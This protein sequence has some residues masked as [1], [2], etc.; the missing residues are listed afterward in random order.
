M[1]TPSP[2][3]ASSMARLGKKVPPAPEPA[4]TSSLYQVVLGWYGV[5]GTV[6]SY[7]LPFRLPFA[8][9]YAKEYWRHALGSLLLALGL[10]GGLIGLTVYLLDANDFKGQIVDYVKANKQRDLVLEGDLQLDFFPQLGLD[11]GKMSLSQ[12]NSSRTF[13]AVDNARLYIAWWPLLRGRLQVERVVLDGLH[14]D[15]VRHTDGS[16]NFDDLLVSAAKLA[17]VDFAMEKLR[18]QRAHV[19]YRD[20]AAGLNLALQDLEL[21]TGRLADATAGRI[22][23]RFQLVSEQPRIDTRVRLGGHLLYEH[24]GL[25]YQFKDV[26]ARA[27]G[28]VAGWSGL[29]LDLRGSLSAQPVL[30]L[31]TLQQFDA[32]VRGPWAGQSAELRLR[33]DQL[34]LEA[35]Q[36]QGKALKLDGKLQ[37]EGRQLQAALDVP[38]L[39]SREQTLRSEGLQATL[40]LDQGSTRLQ[41]QLA[42]PAVLDYATRQLQLPSLNGLWNASHALLAG[43]LIA[44]RFNGK[45]QADWGRQDARLDFSTEIEDS[46][47][48]GDVQLQDFRAPAWTFNV[49]ATRLDLDR[50]LVGDWP[51]RLQAGTQVQDWRVLQG[52]NLRGRL[53]TEELRAARLQASAVSIG[54]RVAAGTLTL[55]PVQAQLYGGSFQGE[56]SLGAI[57]DVTG[58]A[59]AVHLATRQK[60][61]NV[62]AEDL[63]ALLPGGEGRLS[64]RGQFTLDV[65]AQGADLVA[66]RQSLTG[67]ASV[68]LARGTLAGVDLPEALLAA[69]DLLG[70]ED[71]VQQDR[72]RLTEETPYTDLK[73][74]WQIADGQARSSDLL[75]KT[76]TLNGKG[77]VRYALESGE[78]DA[79]LSVQVLPGL[80]RAIGGELAELAGITVPLQIR[81]PW[82]DAAVH[83]QLGQASGPALAQLLRTR[84]A[85][86]APETAASATEAGTTV[87]TSSK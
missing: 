24:A 71:M 85:R 62:P 13:A 48:T 4:P 27:Q 21:E 72:L 61:S 28:Q 63:L 75:L 37:Q 17:D 42:G 57:A 39:Q 49:S 36:W 1:D 10:I 52:L 87:N 16:S 7:V 38:A 9:G 8:E 12:R 33:A 68:A 55:E 56:L 2:V 74:S 65:Q 45:L 76:P 41:A 64:G 86:V 15:V 51:A 40:A 5:V 6:L 22:D 59:S 58:P 29:D 26:E 67:T 70:Q 32:I 78:L 79:Q 14:A 69:R 50:H 19:N 84:P 80:K 83:Y 82:A 43:K 73:A 34:K 81:G 46:T 30:H 18:V 20:D 47:L 11:T 53:R 60:F 35:G 25:R 23:A 77:D 44:T 3:T 66:L 54:L 31:L